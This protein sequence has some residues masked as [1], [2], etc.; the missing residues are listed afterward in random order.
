MIARTSLKNLVG[1]I[2]RI[3]SVR[4]ADLALGDC[5]IVDTRNS[6]YRI[7]SLGNG[8]FRVSGGWFERAGL[9]SATAGI[10]GCTFGGTVIHSG[11]AAGRGLFL[12]FDNNVRTTRIVRFRI[13]PQ[14]HPEI[15]H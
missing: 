9:T 14:G 8:L 7:I 1:Q 6:C 15:V 5:L 3:P 12:E 4:K 10:N 11:L 2:D 13:L